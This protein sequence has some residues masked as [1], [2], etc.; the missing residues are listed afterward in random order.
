MKGKLGH[1][2]FNLVL[3]IFISHTQV[4]LRKVKHTHEEVGTKPRAFA[5]TVGA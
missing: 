1:P 4:Q 3:T 2:G 5:V